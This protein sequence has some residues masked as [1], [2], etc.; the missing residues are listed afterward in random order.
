MKHL[1]LAA[2]AF[3]VSVT[4]AGTADA[5]KKRVNV[6]NKFDG[7][8]SIQVVTEDGPCE[9]AYR[10]AL[11]IYNGEAVYPGGDVQIRGRVSSSGAVSGI[12]SRGNDAARVQGRLT[13]QGSGSGHWGSIGD[14]PIS[15]RGSWN[16]VRRG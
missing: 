6:P 9:R 10:Y 8:W 5:A 12:I 1:F 16:A 14:S 4:A 11:Q 13:V 3:A 15:C 2:A 7:N